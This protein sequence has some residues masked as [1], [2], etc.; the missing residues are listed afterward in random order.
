MLNEA[1][2]LAS[3]VLPPAEDRRWAELKGFYDL[4]MSQDGL[5]PHP[6]ARF[7]AAEIRQKVASR[8]RLR[9]HTDMETIVIAGSE[10]HHVRV[11]NVSR[12]GA[13]V[14]C[15]R[16]F[17][18]GT[19]L[20]LHLAS[21]ERGAGLLPAD[22]QVVWRSESTSETGLFRYRLGLQFVRLDDSAQRGLDALVVDSLEAKLLSLRRETLDAEFLR[23]ERV[24]L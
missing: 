10:V 14:H 2:T 16:G 8:K 7:S 9:V 22:G 1:K 21:L 23:R 17:D 20:T 19:E 3:G 4:V 6:A 13:L 24:S 15:D 18:V 11:A 12:G 5:A